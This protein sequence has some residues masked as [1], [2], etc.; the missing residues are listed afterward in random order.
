MF[1]NEALIL[2][3]WRTHHSVFIP[4]LSK[5]NFHLTTAQYEIVVKNARYTAQ[6][7]KNLF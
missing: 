4:S 5:H 6:F 1:D 7:F 2:S 3:L